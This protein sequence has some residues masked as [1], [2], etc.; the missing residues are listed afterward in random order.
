MYLYVER[1]KLTNLFHIDSK[2]IYEENKYRRS[3]KGTLI[4]KEEGSIFFNY[5]FTKYYFDKDTEKFL[6]CIFNW[7]RTYMSLHE[8]YACGIHEQYEYERQVAEFGKC[9]IVLPEKGTFKILAEEILSPFYVFQIIWIIVWFIDEYWFYSIIIL[10]TYAISITTELIDIKENMKNLREM[11]DYEC[12]ITVKRIDS[13]GKVVYREVPSNDLVPGDIILVPERMKMPWDAIQLTGSSIMNEAMLTGE[14]I[15]V[16]KN[17]L[18]YSD[19]EIYNFKKDKNYTFYSGTEVVQN[20]NLGCHE[21]TALVIKTNFDTM[22]G[23]LVKSI[24]YPKPSRFSF[25]SDSMKFIGLMAIISIFGYIL[26]LPQSIKYL[27]LKRLILKGIN[28]L[29]LAVPPTLPAA[30]TVGISFA[31]TRLSKSKIFWIDPHKIN[32]A[33][34]VKSIVF[35]KTGTL[36]EDSLGFAGVTLSNKEKFSPLIED[37]SSLFQKYNENKLHGS[38]QKRSQEEIKEQSNSLIDSIESRWVEWMVSCHSIAQLDNKFIGDPLEIEMFKVTNWE[39]VEEAKYPEEDSESSNEDEQSPLILGIYK[40]KENNNKAE[41]LTVVKHF[42][43]SSALQ[44]MSV[45]T[46]RNFDGSYVAFVKGSPEMIH[47]LSNKDSIPSDYLNRLERYTKD[48]LR[49]LAFGY[50]VLPKLCSHELKI[51]KRE[52]IEWDLTF[53]GLLIMENKIKPETLPSI[54]KLQE[55]NVMTIMATGDNGLT[56]ISVGRNCGMISNKKSVFYAELIKNEEG[57]KVLK[58]TKFDASIHL[59]RF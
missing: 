29:S 18:P 53:I 56:G 48:G 27:S 40:P 2:E 6:P 44:R 33:G 34:L 38:K 55:A 42:E 23:S 49:V 26:V 13:H 43:F 57:E 45:V 7:S 37:V 31:L 12:Q 11:V 21:V 30:M 35:D 50:K 1:S 51:L 32:A 47:K 17:P 22:K 54:Q 5:R 16:I 15:P 4:P 39:I 58:W 41:F 24:L 10:V 8:G 25:V 20:R 19:S 52:E 3:H 59:N 14:S 28:L 36:T 46:K 9:S